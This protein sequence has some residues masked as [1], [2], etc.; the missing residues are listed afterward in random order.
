MGGIKFLDS[1]GVSLLL[2]VNHSHGGRYFDKC[3]FIFTIASWATNTY[4]DL[5][6][7]DNMIRLAAIRAA[8]DALDQ[9]M[10]ELLARRE[11]LVHQVIPIKVEEGLPARIQVRVDAV[12][13]N[14]V[15][16]AASAGVDAD[17]A[18]TVWTAM[19][20]W[21]VQHEEKLLVLKRQ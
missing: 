2:P 14:A 3:Y 11:A 1:H 6:K 16:R 15:K 10:L 7:Q 17:L 5:M 9:E 21:F 8:I 18:R 4:T 20:E 12:V 13:E 19:V